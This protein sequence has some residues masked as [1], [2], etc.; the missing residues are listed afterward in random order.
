MNN[1]NSYLNDLLINKYDY[2]EYSTDIVHENIMIGGNKDNVN[3]PTGGFPP[4]FICD[5]TDSNIDV[6]QEEPSK[7]RTY[8]SSKKS[9]SITDILNKRRKKSFTD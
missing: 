4:I 9:V 1:I 3:K 5:N 7:E 8:V 2:S 6:Y